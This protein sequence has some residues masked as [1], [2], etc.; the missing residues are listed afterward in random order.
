MN[1]LRYFWIAEY[2]DRTALPQF[3]PETGEE[4]LFAEV[5]QLNLIKFGWYPF[6][7]ELVKKV[8]NSLYNPFLPK[9]ILNVN[10]NDKIIVRR[11]NYIERI[12]QA[13]K[14]RT[15]YLLGNQNFIMIIDEYG[16]VE[17]Q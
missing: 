2:K 9:Y 14:R 15:E 1:S 8:K 12:G 7:E 5:N 6:S 17:V 16:N 13:E 3:D 4:N 10:I 11:R